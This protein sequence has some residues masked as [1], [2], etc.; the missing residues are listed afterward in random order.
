MDRPD[1]PLTLLVAHHGRRRSWHIDLAPL[2]PWVSRVL[3]VEDGSGAYL[4]PL[5][6]RALPECAVT[7][8]PLAGDAASGVWNRDLRALLDA[9]D[10]WLLLLPAGCGV[11]VDRHFTLPGRLAPFSVLH[12]RRSGREASWRPALLPAA[13]DCLSIAGDGSVRIDVPFSSER[14]HPGMVIDEPGTGTG[15]E[16]RKPLETALAA[17]RSGEDTGFDVAGRLFELGRFQ[18]AG[19]WYRRCLASGIEGA[20][21]WTALYRFARCLQET[22]KPWTVVEPALVEAFDE[23]PDRAE[24]LYHLARHCLDSGDNRKAFDLAAVGIALELPRTPRPFEYPVYQYELP[25]IYMAAALALG[26]DAECIREANRTLRRPGLPESDREAIAGLRSRAVS[27]CQPV[28]PVSIRRRNRIVVVTAFRNAGSFLRRCTDSL[29]SQDYT[30]S[31]FILIDDASTDG[32]LDHVDVSD[33]RFTVIRNLE[34]RGAIRN[35]LDAIREH[36]SPEDI[37]VYVDGDDR[38][39]DD[40]ALSFIND[41]FNATRCLVMYGQYRDSRERYGRCEPIV[42][43][44]GSVLDAVGPMHFPMHVRAHRA[45]LVDRLEEID[46]AL[47]RLRDDDGEFLDAVADMAV[48]RAVMQLAGLERIRYNDRILYEYNAGNPESHYRAV[49]RRLH[50]DQQARMLQSRPPLPPVG[51]HDSGVVGAPA[52]TSAKAGLLLVALDGM[53]PRLIHQW[54]SEGHLPALGKLL[55]SDHIRDITVPR[56]F[57]N[58]AFWASFCTGLLPD[59]HGYYFRNRWCPAEHA[60]KFCDL[61]NELGGELFWERL[62]DTDLEMALID[63]PEVKHAGRVN[64]LEVTDWVTHARLGPPRF[65][66]PELK[67]DWVGRFGLDPTGG[68]T[69][70]MAMRTGR[71]VVKLRDQLLASVEQKTRAALHYLDRGGWDLFALGYTQGHDAGHQFWHVHDPA[72]PAHR[73]LWLERYGDPLLQTYQAVD[74]GLGRLMERA[75]GAARV[76]VVAGVAMEAKASCSAVLDEV[77]WA[78]EQ[79]ELG[80]RGDDVDRRDLKQRRFFAVPHN[81]IAGT[82]RINLKD[83]ETEAGLVERGED[84]RRTLDVLQ[85]CLGR[86]VNADTGEPVVSELVRTQ[87]VYGGSRVDD[88][89]DL[90]VIWDRRSPIRRIAS[91]WFGEMQVRPKGVLDTR[92]GDHVGRAQMIT[93]FETPFP[94][95][96]PVPVQDI[97]PMLVDLV[98]K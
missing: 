94:G 42:E 14:C 6:A 5:L 84:Y 98:R 37:V 59:E 93:S 83:R 61:E 75:G 21:R 25:G 55:E 74:R 56:G 39:I 69:E 96:G 43:S 87:D 97:A 70:T 76:M 26:R 73:A 71:Q 41:F 90:F 92:S 2:R 86:V 68:N 47:H 4:L 16:S 38:L 49:E 53:T 89:P 64:G 63:L 20:D 28:F 80:V 30:E 35:Q 72:H 27:R 62:A 7:H 8:L 57:G 66:P 44:E 82:V 11:R 48:M 33:P 34:R 40:G 85:H 81:N 50:Q 79:A 67:D 18:E 52:R 60:L 77:L 19:F 95:S 46:P 23:D 32:A 12:R 78:I 9:Q 31:R 45:H 1:L 15:V 88:L 65:F 58:D 17:C 54:V 24:P 10:G 91:P 22:G 3:L 51:R 13:A 29:A 36:C